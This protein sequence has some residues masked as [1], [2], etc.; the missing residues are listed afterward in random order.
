MKRGLCLVAIVAAVAV[1]ASACAEDP[2]GDGS[3]APGGS[4]AA[5]FE[6]PFDDVQAYP[7]FASSEVVEGENRFLIGLLNDEDAPIASPDVSMHVTFYDLSESAE[8][9]AFETDA[10]FID[11]GP[12]GLY[13]TY[14]TFDSTGKWGAEV[15]VEGEGLEETVRASFEVAD[16]STT[17]A[18]GERVPASDTPTASGRD[19]E[20]ITTD[21]K[22][23][24]SF[25]RTSIRD[26]VKDGRPFVVTFATPKFCSSAVCAPTLD[27]VKGESE[28]WRGIEFIHVE[29]YRL[30]SAPDL[31]P[32]EAVQE[33][34]LPSEPWVFVVGGDGKLVAKFE[35]TVAPRE[36]EDA[37]RRV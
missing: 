4:E 20:E 23:D 34:G 16:D 37:L 27:I 25:Y 35:G 31:E 3:A 26:A 5:S 14:P 30:D 18:I 19:L 1:T 8:R 32:V 10:R 12:R 36:L 15:T 22:P 33:W 24:P 7:V 17:P 13:V 28:D 6:Q 2:G 9:P 29:V 11:T 21:T